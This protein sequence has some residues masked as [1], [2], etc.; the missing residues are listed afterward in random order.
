MRTGVEGLGQSVRLTA[1]ERYSRQTILPEVG[2][3]G[4]KRIMA[5]SALIVGL[6]GLGAPVAMYL[7]AAGVGR[8]GLADRDT[9]SLSNLQRQVLY[10]EDSVG[11]YKTEY[12]ARRLRTLSSD[13][14]FE[15][16]DEGLSEGNAVALI[17]AYDI[18][19]DCTDNFRTRMLIDNACYI[20]GKP[21]VHGAIDGFRGMVTVFNHKEKKRYADLYPDCHELRDSK[22]IIGTFGVIPGVIGSLQASEALKVLGGFGEPLE[23]KLI[24][25]DIFTNSF[26]I[27]EY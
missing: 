18:V 4:Q 5:S 1:M 22:S 14:A 6:G 13:T 12:A 7:T 2:E 16:H 11:R 20:T 27:I 10:S 17:G 25:I 26:N 23:S 19:L 9:V 8:I 3:E 15:K 21:W 24:M